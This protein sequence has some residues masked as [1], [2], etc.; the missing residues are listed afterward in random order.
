MHAHTD[1][2]MSEA[3]G[4]RPCRQHVGSHGWNAWRHVHVSMLAAMGYG[5]LPMRSRW[6]GQTT[7][8]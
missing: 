8:T 1:M 6:H 3:V 2:R 5:G 7:V 4:G